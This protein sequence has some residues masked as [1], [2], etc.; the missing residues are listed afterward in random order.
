MKQERQRHDGGKWSCFAVARSFTY[1]FAGVLH[2]LRTERNLQIH[3]L[4]TTV[5]LGWCLII[6]P[7]TTQVTVALITCFLIWSVELV[8]TALERV[9][10]LAADGRFVDLARQA[11]DVAAGA[12]L[13]V[14]LASLSAGCYLVVSTYPWQWRLLSTVH[15]LGAVES[16]LA[17]MFIVIV[18]VL[19]RRSSVSTEAPQP[20]SAKEASP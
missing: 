5:V 20:G 3:C 18:F 19:S 15:G 16:G 9:T 14:C 4:A 2:A 7:T 13:M 11:K 12:V 6:R 1:A 8:N 10:D 17:L